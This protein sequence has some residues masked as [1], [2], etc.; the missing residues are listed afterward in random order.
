VTVT[1]HEIQRV[2]G[3]FADAIAGRSMHLQ[4]DDD[5]LAWPWAVGPV[6]DGETV[7]VPAAADRA[8]YRASVLHQTGFAEFGTLDLDPA[9]RDAGFAA[10]GR[11]G[12]TRQLFT[13]LEDLRIAAATRRQY[14]GAHHELDLVCAEARAAVD[15]DA[16]LDDLRRHALGGPPPPGLDEILRT[17]AL[18]EPTATVTDSARAAIEIAALIADDVEIDAEAT[19]AVIELPDPPPAGLEPREEDPGGGDVPRPPSLHMEQD[20]DQPQ[21]GGQI[22]EL[23]APDP[24]RPEAETERPPGHRRGDRVD[25]PPD[26]DRDARVFWYDEWS[27]VGRRYLRAWCRVVE[28]RLHGDDPS[29]IAD[30]RRR[31]AVLASRVRRQFSFVRPE[32]WVRVHHADDGDELDLDAVIEAVVDRRTGLVPDDRLHVRRER[33]ARDVATAFLVD[34]SASTTSPVVDE[35]DRP[36]PT[37]QEVIE[38]RFAGI[39]PADMPP[40]P[41]ARRVLDVAKESVA[42]MCDALDVL[43]DRHAVYG[44][45]GEGRD[46]VD[47][48]VAKDFDDR[49]SPATWA[50]IGAMRS[51]RYT[52]MG[53][54]VRHATAKLTAQPS[55]TKQLVVISDGYPQD[56]D[57][58]P[59]RGDNEYGL[60]DTARALQE[61]IEAGVH[62]YCVTIDPA[63][64]DYLRRMCPA[65]SYVVIDD[66]GALPREL[67]NLYRAVAISR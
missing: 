34:L 41:Q 1:F 55:R 54:A 9:R 52:R 16:L 48:H 56:I 51:L 32:G 47:V 44:F 8:A 45:S 37:E 42:L 23:L 63:G 21:Q 38:Y 14:P 57:Y 36:D 66:V 7:R 15:G 50:A 2:L 33:A 39:D 59:T 67:T 13:I 18:G 60:Q 6:P 3:L 28:R 31:H 10:T 30:V 19:F 46:H 35:D 17:A 49:T 12:L 53:P 5:D 40:P 22:V 26:D 61:A 62:P 20:D 24:G 58:G 25:R 27:Y 29:F 65:G 11:P 64:H 43:G 4:P